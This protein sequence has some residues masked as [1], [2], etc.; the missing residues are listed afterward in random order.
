MLNCFLFL[1]KGVMVGSGF[2]VPSLRKEVSRTTTAIA[3]TSL[4]NTIQC[5]I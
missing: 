2:L 5:F 1:I 3:V 4:Y